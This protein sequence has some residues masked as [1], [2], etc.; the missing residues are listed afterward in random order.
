[1]I[2]IISSLILVLTCLI[3]FGQDIGLGYVFDYGSEFNPKIGTDFYSQKTQSKVHSVFIRF[4]SYYGLNGIQLQVGY[5]RDSIGFTNTSE[6]L[7]FENNEIINFNSEAFIIRESLKF[8]VIDHIQFGDPDDFVFSINAG[9]FYEQSLSATKYIE[10]VKYKLKEEINT[11]CFGAIIGIELRAFGF[12]VVGAK[13]EKIF[14]DILN[15]D[16]INDLVPQSNNG[17]E[18]R[19]LRLDS[20]YATVYI[21]VNWQIWR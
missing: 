18:M 13:Y 17:S 4:D 16:Y 6:Y 5:K 1:M 11:G 2:K 15:H 20:Q 10:G 3:G 7:A 14:N 12:L 8:A 19:G 21:G 9:I